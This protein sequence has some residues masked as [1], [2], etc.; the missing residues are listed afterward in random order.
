MDATQYIRKELG[1]CDDQERG[2]AAMLQRAHENYDR[3]L[4]AIHRRRAEILDMWDQP[5]VNVRSTYTREAMIYHS[6]ARPCRRLNWPPETMFEGEAKARGL[7]RCSACGWP[8]AP[9]VAA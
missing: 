7:R 2:A 4:Q 1:K 3:R 6:T 8:S 9:E 5:L